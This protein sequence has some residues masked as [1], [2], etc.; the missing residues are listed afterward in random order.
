MIFQLLLLEVFPRV[1]MRQ[2][3]IFKGKRAPMV[4]FSRDIK[5]K[6]KSMHH[7]PSYPVPQNPQSNLEIDSPPPLGDVFPASRPAIGGSNR[8]I[9]ASGGGF[10]RSAGIPSCGHSLELCPTVL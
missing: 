3:R 6:L 4:F 8:L 9:L 2:T 10:A 5:E 7:I 1:G